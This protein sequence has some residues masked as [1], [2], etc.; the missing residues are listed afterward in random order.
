MGNSFFNDRYI[1]TSADTWTQMT[2]A[3]AAV[4]D[5]MAMTYDVAQNKLVGWYQGAGARLW[6][7]Q[8]K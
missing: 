6:I 3:G 8:L 1:R 2:S 7:G 5:T 4:T